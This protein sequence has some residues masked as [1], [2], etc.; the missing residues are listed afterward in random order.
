[1]GAS[2]LV[3]IRALILAPILGLM[4]FVGFS[5]LMGTPPLETLSVLAS[6]FGPSRWFLLGFVG[7]TFLVI[8]M[9]SEISEQNRLEKAVWSCASC[10]WRGSK[11]RVN[12]SGGCPNCGSDLFD[13]K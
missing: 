13:L 12:R 5:W 11:K 10:G 7:L 2:K 9:N 1:M 4:F 3:F 8:I 6:G